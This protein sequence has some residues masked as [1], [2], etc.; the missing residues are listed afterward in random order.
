MSNTIPEHALVVVADGGKALLFRRTGA[1]E[2]V[3]L[4]EERQ[5]TP[6]AMAEQG[7]AGS[8]PEEQTPKQTGEASFANHLAHMLHSMH[9]HGEFEDLVLVVDP[10]T[11]GQIRGCLHKTVEAAIVRT[12][13]KDLTNHSYKAIETA[14]SD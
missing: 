14:L 2:H 5:V 13:P 10:Q 4:R 6:D 7:P 1:G 8:R 3:T 9:Q 12:V 11:L